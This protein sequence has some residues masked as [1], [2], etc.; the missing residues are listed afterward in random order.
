LLR[1]TTL[2]TTVGVPQVLVSCAVDGG[3]YV[4]TVA[5]AVPNEIPE[6]AVPPEI[7]LVDPNGVASPASDHTVVNVSTVLV[8]LAL[9]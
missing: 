6:V 9:I 1:Y 4:T 8:L 7:L 5:G 2:A 3:K